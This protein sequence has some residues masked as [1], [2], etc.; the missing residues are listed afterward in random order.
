[1]DSLDLVSIPSNP[2]PEGA[3]PGIVETPDGFRLR[4]ARFT[5]TVRPSRGTVVIAQGRAESIEKYFETITDLQ[6]RGFGVLAFDW[7]GQGGSD[8]V[9]PD[10]RRGHIGSFGEYAIDLD[11][12]MT[13][14]ALPDCR[15]PFFLLAH[16]MGA[17]ASLVAGPRVN[18]RFRRM[19]LC[20]PFL[21]FGSA[22]P[23][24]QPTLAGLAATFSWFGL[25]GIH[26]TTSRTRDARSFIG[27]TLTSDQQRFARNEALVAKEP[28][29]G[30]AGPT[31]GWIH[32]STVAMREVWSPELMARHRT[33]TLLVAAGAD[34][35]ADPRAAADYGARLRAGAQLTIPAARHE[36]LQERDVVREPLLAAFDA[37]VP[38]TGEA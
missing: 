38:G 20:A 18:S 34:T 30:L 26:A 36:L 6:S 37:F 13:Q 16:S 1:M 22:F 19:V 33:P 31:V 5:T 3:R 24:T 7:R 27:N 12:V 4:Y 11:A 8:R 2:V 25:S 21:R 32:A 14:V 10:P 15:G 28:R 23:L 9:H 35:L 17:L 29:L